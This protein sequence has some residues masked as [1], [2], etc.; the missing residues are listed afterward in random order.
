VGGLYSQAN[1]IAWIMRGLSRALVRQGHTVDAYA[2]ECL[3]RE[4]LRDFFESPTRWITAPG[5]WLGGLSWSPSLRSKLRRAMAETDVVHNH[6]LWMLPNRYSSQAARRTGKPVIISAHGTLEPWALRH[7]R[8]KKR[9][10]SA[11]FQRQDL[12][13]ASCIHVN[14]RQEARAIRGLGLKNAVAI[15]PNGVDL[16]QGDRR[17]DAGEFSQRYPEAFAK[18]LVLFMARLHP[19]KGVE[20]LLRAWHQVHGDHGD[21]HLVV[22]GPDGGLEGQARALATQLGIASSVTFTGHLEGRAKRQALAAAS[23]FILPS[24]SEGFSMAVLEAMAARIPVI[25]TPGCHF[26]EAIRGGA[27]IEVQPDP[28][29]TARGLRQLMECSVAERAKMGCAARSLVEQNYTWER[30]A[31]QMLEVYAWLCHDR[32]RPETVVLE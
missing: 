32:G 16:E 1:G 24:R 29:D 21:W 30:V 28:D 8:W 13:R 2:A 14:S 17:T 15:I 20:T 11:C 22:A 23:V 12:Q 27:G 18:K 19:K 6:S 31:R 5:L 7:A 4:S 10:V 25:I 3:G 9:I 26:P